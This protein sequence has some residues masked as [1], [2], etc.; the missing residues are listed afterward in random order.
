MTLGEKQE[1]FSQLFARLVL[2]AI[3]YGFSVS[4][5]EVSRGKEQ[6]QYNATHCARCKRTE[7]YHGPDAGSEAHAFRPIGILESLHCIGLAGDLRL[8]KYTSGSKKQ[9]LRNSRDYQVLGDWWKG[10]HKLARWGGDFQ[11]PDGGH[12]SLEHNGR[13]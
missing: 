7:A 2:F 1:V 10:T 13:R 11:S 4:I 6:A 5:G 8:F 3:Q 12:F 9:C